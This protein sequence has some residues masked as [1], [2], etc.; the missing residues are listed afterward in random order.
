MTGETRARTGANATID[1]GA[2]VGYSHDPDAPPARLGD[3]A[4]VRAGT[5]I[6]TGV[7][8]GDDFSTG[9][10]ALVREDT[11]IGDDV[12]VGTDAVLDGTTTI[13]SHV[14]LQTGVYLP[15]NTT[16]GDQ[17]FVGPRAVLTNDPH[18][19]RREADLAGPTLEDGVSV[20]ANA[21]LLPDITIGEGSF[22]AAGAVVTR[23]VPP[24]TLA[25]GVPARHEPLPD[26]LSGGN[27][28]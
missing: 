16:V 21:T 8:T 13:G 20:G 18:P 22:V 9:H 14:S 2:T 10:N 26:S 11:T 17:V 6:Y 19:V 7:E 12:L 3:D 24:E 27:S 1:D 28:I 5:I 15:T 25:V 23:D 4:T